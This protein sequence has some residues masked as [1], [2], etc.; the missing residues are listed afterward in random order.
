MLHWIML[1]LNKC[2]LHRYKPCER[3]TIAEESGGVAGLLTTDSRVSNSHY[4]YQ[5]E[6]SVSQSSAIE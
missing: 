6:Q 5:I 1:R 3:H 2:I 4:A